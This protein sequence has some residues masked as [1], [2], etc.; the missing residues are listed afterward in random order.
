MVVK[1]DQASPGE[2]PQ[3]TSVSQTTFKF[4][5]IQR[6]TAGNCE[7]R[8]EGAGFRE[9]L[10]AGVEQHASSRYSERGRGQS[11]GQPHAPAIAGV[12]SPPANIHPPST[13]LRQADHEHLR[14]VGGNLCGAKWT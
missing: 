12:P 8:V 14:S 7:G 2:V 10:R 6:A 13:S 5:A 3:G 1:E 9:D 11:A 4:W